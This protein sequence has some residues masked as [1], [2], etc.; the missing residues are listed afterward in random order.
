MKKSTICKGL[1]VLA[2]AL[3]VA[4]PVCAW[5]GSGTSSD[6][7]QISTYEDLK[8]VKDYPGAYFKQTADITVNDPSLF[9]FNDDNVII[10]AKLS[11]EAWAP[12]ENFTGTYDGNNK[13]ITGLYVNEDNANGG[14]F[15]YVN[16]GKVNNLN[17]EYALVE[18]DEYAGILAGN[19]AAG[20]FN[21]KSNIKRAEAATILGR[22]GGIIDRAKK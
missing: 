17:F 12:V 7:Y 1:L 10:N 8:K 15:A 3:A 11:A 19:D 22:L 13:Y 4:V 20:T 21:P 16:G 2:L 18:S 14:L 5:S 9:E 6:P